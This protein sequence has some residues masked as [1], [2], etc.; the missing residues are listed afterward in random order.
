MNE[1]VPERWHIL[2]CFQML[3]RND[4]IFVKHMEKIP[5]PI[6]LA[7]TVKR[8]EMIADVYDLLNA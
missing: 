5:I 4:S 7:P 1:Q 3:F 6:R 8:Y 2:E